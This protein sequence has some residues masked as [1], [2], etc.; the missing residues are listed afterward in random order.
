MRGITTFFIRRVIVKP[1]LATTLE[2]S[3]KASDKERIDCPFLMTSRVTPS[4]LQ[5]SVFY[6]LVLARDWWGFVEELGSTPTPIAP[7][8]LL[9]Y[10]LVFFG[11]PPL[12]YPIVGLCE[13]SDDEAPSTVKETT[14]GT[15]VSEGPADCP[16]SSNFFLYSTH[17]PSSIMEKE[18]IQSKGKLKP[19]VANHLLFYGDAIANKSSHSAKQMHKVISLTKVIPFLLSVP[20]LCS[21]PYPRGFSFRDAL[22]R[23]SFFILLGNGDTIGIPSCLRS[24]SSSLGSRIQTLQDTQST[25][26]KGQRK[27]GP[28]LAEASLHLHSI[29]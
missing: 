7:I 28:T 5:K 17:F 29:D 18:P 10:L 26:P 19:G 24:N 27:S 1:T 4:S 2:K 12:L 9:N 21:L 13:R 23:D 6:S 20:L 14:M 22:K 16:S 15:F 8:V 25:L 11:L 3:F